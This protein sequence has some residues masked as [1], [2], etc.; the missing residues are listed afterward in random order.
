MQGRGGKWQSSGVEGEKP[1][2]TLRGGASMPRTK[3]A[4]KIVREIFF[5]VYLKTRYVLNM[6][7]DEQWCKTICTITLSFFYQFSSNQNLIPGNIKTYLG[8]C[9]TPITVRAKKG[10]ILLI[11]SYIVFHY[12]TLEYSIMLCVSSRVLSSLSYCNIL[13][14]PYV[15]SS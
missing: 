15:I 1:G 4:N 12:T 5:Y 10:R 7:N 2:V 6:K 13:S 14:M 11:Q 9:V 3:I 8:V